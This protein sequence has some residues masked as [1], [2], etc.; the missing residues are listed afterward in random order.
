MWCVGY[1]SGNVEV[2]GVVWCVGC[3]SGNVEVVGVVCRVCV[4]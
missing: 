2:V 1:V 4:R 3:V